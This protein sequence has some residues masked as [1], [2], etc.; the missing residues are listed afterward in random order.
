[1][2]QG[3]QFAIRTLCFV[4]AVF[5]CACVL[6]SCGRQRS[7]SPY[8]WNANAAARYLDQRETNWTTWHGAARDHDTFC[9][10][11]HTA[12]SYA[13]IRPAIHAPG[14]QQ[15]AT[16]EEAQLIQDVQKRV[17]LWSQVGP[18]YQGQN[19]ESRG[20]ESVLNALIL[21]TNDARSGGNLSVDT[22]TAFENMW[23]LQKTS[24]ARAGTWSWLQFRQ[25]P[26]EA[27]DSDYYG[28]CLAALAV[29]TAPDAYRETAS[30]QPNLMLLRY[31][32]NRNFET[33]TTINKVTF[34]W[35]SLKWPQLISAG[36]RR[37]II[38]EAYKKQRKD[39]GWSSATLIGDWKRTDGTPLVLESDGYA[40]GLITYVLQEAGVP[41]TDAHLNRGL[42]WLSRSQSWWNGHWSAYSLNRRRHDP[43]SNVS[44]FMNDAATAYAAL[45]LTEADYHGEAMNLANG[46]NDQLPAHG[47]PAASLT[48]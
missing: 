33:Q 17:Q 32:L 24:G 46:R 20:T 41:Q 10:S 18:Y 39:G 37:S 44:Q 31:Y 1:M 7:G 40:T 34:L 47:S 38:D 2:N 6:S 14:Q 22:Q 16:G 35:A 42:T 43:F 48:H 23:A 26:W 9:V 30:I 13:L 8:A 3:F 27:R 5:A 15:T 36:Q 28:A 11:C 45:S 29:G 25:E 12:L 21:A 4:S 19:E